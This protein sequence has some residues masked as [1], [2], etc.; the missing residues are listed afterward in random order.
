M[1]EWK[2]LDLELSGSVMAINL[3]LM[4]G[5]G[6]QLSNRVWM[7]QKKERPIKLW[8]LFPFRSLTITHF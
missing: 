7:S 1:N 3:G 6:E 5:C 2:K 8:C 4:G